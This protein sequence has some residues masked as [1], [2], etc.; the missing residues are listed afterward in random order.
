MLEFGRFDSA[1]L[2][3]PFD[4]ST[5]LSICLADSNP[6]MRS[7]RN[8]PQWILTILLQRLAVFD[9]AF[10]PYSAVRIANHGSVLFESTSLHRVLKLSP[11]LFSKSTGQSTEAEKIE[12]GDTIT[13]PR[14]T[15]GPSADHDRDAARDTARRSGTSTSQKH[16]LPGG[17]GPG[18]S[19]KPTSESAMEYDRE[20]AYER[21]TIAGHG[22]DSAAAYGGGLADTH[23][24]RVQRS[25]VGKLTSFRK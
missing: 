9:L 17:T 15:A 22:T 18:T 24:E 2:S 20:R 13:S 4:I 23:R 14:D 19:G 3:S 7:M 8:L 25:P 12:N 10:F 16:R 11:G 5:C 1:D 6:E 21:N